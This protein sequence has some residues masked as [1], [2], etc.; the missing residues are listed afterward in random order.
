MM[1][2]IVKDSRPHNCQ[3]SAYEVFCLDGNMLLQ[4]HS[5]PKIYLEC[6]FCP[7]CGNPAK[8]SKHAGQDMSELRRDVEYP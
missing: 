8:K 5:Y 7:I 2:P 3:T 1:D 4:T 6:E